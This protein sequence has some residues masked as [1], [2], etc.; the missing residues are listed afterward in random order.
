M[1]NQISGRPIKVLAF[2][3]VELLSL[4]IEDLPTD[5]VA[6]MDARAVEDVSGPDASTLASSLRR[7]R[8]RRR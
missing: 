2:E 6:D 3:V 4:E 1:S 8:R 5:Y 7:R